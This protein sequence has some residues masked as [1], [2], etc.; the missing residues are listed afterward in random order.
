[1][2]FGIQGAVL[3]DPS[4]V[5]NFPPSKTLQ[6]ELPTFLFFLFLHLLVSSFIG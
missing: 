3:S 1:M 5:R 4:S 2:V 6:E